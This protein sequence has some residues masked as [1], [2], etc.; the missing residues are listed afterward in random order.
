MK[1][2]EKLLRSIVRFE[3]NYS[4]LAVFFILTF[5]VNLAV[6]TTVYVDPVGGI[7][8][9]GG[10]PQLNGGASPGYHH[11]LSVTS[12]YVCASQTGLYWLETSWGG[13]AFQS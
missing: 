5:M 11:S 10:G 8:H 7:L 3:K 13:C 1:K 9:N 4:G 12:S 2:I 6:A